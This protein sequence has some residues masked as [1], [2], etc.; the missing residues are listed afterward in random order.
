MS[1]PSDSVCGASEVETGVLEKYDS[2]RVSSF[3]RYS[4]SLSN[5]TLSKRVKRASLSESQQ[6]LRILDQERC[7]IPTRQ[8]LV[9]VDVLVNL[10]I[11]FCL[12]IIKFLYHALKYIIFLFRDSYIMFFKKSLHSRKEGLSHFGL[13]TMFDASSFSVIHSSSD[14]LKIRID[15]LGKAS[16]RPSLASSSFVSYWI[17]SSS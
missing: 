9:Q 11:E 13:E 1:T 10:L 17:S 12:H 14:V 8:T 16:F 3:S 5:S 6:D 2:F 4:S 15:S 7:R